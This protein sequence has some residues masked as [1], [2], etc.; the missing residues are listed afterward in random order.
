MD[1]PRSGSLIRISDSVLFPHLL[2]KTSLELILV[3]HVW[4]YLLFLVMLPPQRAN[5]L[6]LLAILQSFS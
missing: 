2:K 6:L 5:E 4:F 1:D 3:D